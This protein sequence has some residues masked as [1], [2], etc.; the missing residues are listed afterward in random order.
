MTDVAGAAGNWARRLPRP[1]RLDSEPNCAPAGPARIRG[2]RCGTAGTDSGGSGGRSGTGGSGSGG[3]GGSG[4]AGSGGSGSG[5]GGSG[6]GGTGGTGTCGSGTAGTGGTSTGGASGSGMTDAAPNR[7]PAAPA[8]RS[9]PSDGGGAEAGGNTGGPT[10]YEGELPLYKGP[11]VGP[12]VTMACPGDPTTGF[13]EYE[14]TFHLERP[15]DLAI[16]TRF[17]IED[18]IYYF[19]VQRNDKPHTRTTMALN[20][21]TEARYKQN[22]TTGIRMWS[23]DVYLERNTNGSVIMQ[24]HTTTTGIG[25]I[26]LH[27]EG[28]NLEQRREQPPR[29]DPVALATFNLRQAPRPEDRA[30]ESCAVS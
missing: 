16:N 23:G 6:T 8:D 27:V 2:R 19:W 22:F 5:T 20:P 29:L 25:P 26:Y 3:I 9:G 12:E 30:S 7:G 10:S 17:K 13:V 24:V 18:G 15:Y 4:T 21:R 14:D 11:P 1:P 28:N